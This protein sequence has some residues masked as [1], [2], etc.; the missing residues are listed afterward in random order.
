MDFWQ[1]RSSNSSRI[2]NIILSRKENNKM[3]NIWLI[4][5]KIFW[6]SNFARFSVLKSRQCVLSKNLFRWVSRRQMHALSWHRIGVY[7]CTVPVFHVHFGRTVLYVRSV[8][9]T[10]CVL[11]VHFSALYLRI[12]QNTICL[13]FL[14][15]FSEAVLAWDVV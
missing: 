5:R 6:K 13:L 3:L 14:F 1:T 9:S 12:R 10:H 15:A 11:Y 8:C 4:E 7:Y 2:L